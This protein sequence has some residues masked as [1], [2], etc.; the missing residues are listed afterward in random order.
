MKEIIYLDHAATTRTSDT[1]LAEMLPFYNKYYGNASGIY[2][3]S[4]MSKSAI[5]MA[6]Q[7][8]A[9]AINSRTNE[10]Y[11]VSGGSEADNLA[12][13]GVA[14]ANRIRGNHIITTKIEHKAILNTCKSLEKEGFEVTYL[15]VDKN[16]MINLEELRRA[17][18]RSTI[19]ISVMYANNEIRYDSAYRRNWINS[20]K[21]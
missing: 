8:V 18:R 10:I 16:G 5:E 20:E 19:L 3:L 7:K 1:V 21:I 11:F 15:D 14:R 4:M 12:I 13:K 9:K 6:R 17:I 2:F